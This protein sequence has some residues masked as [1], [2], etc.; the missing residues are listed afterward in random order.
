M[1]ALG[2][3]FVVVLTLVFFY[4]SVRLGPTPRRLLSRF[5]PEGGGDVCTQANPFCVIHHDSSKG[6]KGFCTENK[7]T[8]IL[9]CAKVL[10][11]IA[12]RDRLRSYYSSCIWLL[13]VTIVCPW[14]RALNE[15][16]YRQTLD[17]VMLRSLQLTTTESFNQAKNDFKKIRVSF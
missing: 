9:I 10:L 12:K 13:W 3:Y 11:R 5:F 7:S 4:S 1:H 17:I 8:Q 16:L 15:V 6:W 14:G 2:E